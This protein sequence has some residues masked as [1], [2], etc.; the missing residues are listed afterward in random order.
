[1]RALT[2]VQ[3]SLFASLVLGVAAAAGSRAVPFELPDGA[4]WL[5]GRL[6]K[7]FESHYDAR[8]PGKTLGTNVWA[9]IDYL[10][11]DEGRP[12]VVVGNDGWLY[13][14]EE[15]KAYADADATVATHLALIPW[16]RDELAAQGTQLV[17]AM[18][19]S[20]ARIYPEH[21]GARRPSALHDGLYAQAQGALRD[22][23]IAA[24][25]LAVV[26]R[27]CKSA[28][29]TFLRT[30]THWTPAGARCA[31][32]AVQAALGAAPRAVA[33]TPRYQTHVESRAEHSGDLLSF[34]PLAPYFASLLPE[35]DMIEVRRTERMD[36]GGDALLGDA[37]APDVVLIGTSYSADERWNLA[38]ALQ[39]ALQEDVVNYAA[40]GKG[41]FVPMLEYLLNSRDLPT[42]PRLVIWE[43]PER[44]LPMA[45]DLRV[46]RDAPPADCPRD[47]TP[48]ND[49]L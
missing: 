13:T 46:V 17:V 31:A 41:P 36:A 21:L 37:P 11:F 32:Q 18:V 12:G 45:Q 22:A 23:G 34:L 5:D 40:R 48:T 25:D 6:A 24:P 30:D 2:I 14:D 26:M 29:P 44:Y 28:G 3:S 33:A 47:A 42:A 19:P 8:F 10:L 15:F 38:G 20:K 1:M 39:E 7:A 27:E 49:T 9:A 4:D 16:I 43:I 35:P